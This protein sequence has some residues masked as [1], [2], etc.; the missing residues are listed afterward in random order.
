MGVT[1]SGGNLLSHPPPETGPND[2]DI[3]NQP[4]HSKAEDYANL[5]EFFKKDYA[6]LQ[7]FRKKDCIN[8]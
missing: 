1:P 7:E 5:Q 4:R 2:D 8:L 3:D 6:N